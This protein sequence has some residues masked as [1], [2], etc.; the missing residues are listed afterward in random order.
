MNTRRPHD[1]DDGFDEVSL[2]EDEEYQ[3]ERLRKRSGPTNPKRGSHEHKDRFHDDREFR[4]GKRHLRREPAAIK[5]W[6]PRV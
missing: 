5:P 3:F 6:D 4:N 1:F 2:F